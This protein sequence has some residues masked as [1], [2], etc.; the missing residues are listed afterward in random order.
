MQSGS[1]APIIEFENDLQIVRAV[2]NRSLT[3][4]NVR[5]RVGLKLRSDMFE[6]LYKGFRYPVRSYDYSKKVKYSK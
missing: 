4:N 2:H 1:G 6:I 5:S 3:T